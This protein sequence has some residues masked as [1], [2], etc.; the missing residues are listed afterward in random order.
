MT[1]KTSELIDALERQREK[2]IEQKVTFLIQ[3]KIYE[4]GSPE[5]K[6]SI[7]GEDG[8]TK[9][10]SRKDVQSKIATQLKGIDLLLGKIDELIEE[11]K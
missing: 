7:R 3:K 8:K 9:V 2:T 10:E 11:E 5:D 4:G 1:S 6:I